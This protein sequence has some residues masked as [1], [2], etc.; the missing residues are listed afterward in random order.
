MKV[1]SPCAL[2]RSMS[3]LFSRK[4]SSLRDTRRAGG[5]EA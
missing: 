3:A 1:E 4:L 2:W 5:E